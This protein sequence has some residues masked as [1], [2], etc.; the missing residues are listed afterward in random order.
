[1]SAK[2]ISKAGGFTLAEVSVALAVA[3]IFAAAA[4]AT[5]Q[6]LL[7]ML[8]NQRE[9]TA[10]TMMLQEQMEAFRSLTYAQVAS[11][12]LSAT[13]SPSPA[14]GADIVNN[15]TVSEATLGGTN[16]S[17]SETITVSGYMDGN[18]NIPPTTAAQNQWV[19]NSTYP[20]GSLSQSSAVLATNYDLLQVDLRLSWTSAD[21]R[22][23]N[24]ELTSIFG[25]GNIGGN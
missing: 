13:P 17:L 11:N 10:A 15:G 18:G 7:L 2:G 24:R 23:R 3:V 21:G 12:T 14:S 9:T 20:T 8:K 6:R 19:R 1:M 25:R 4:F 16:G 5:N 22:T